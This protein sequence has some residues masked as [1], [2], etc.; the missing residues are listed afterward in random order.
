MGLILPGNYGLTYNTYPFYVLLFKIHLGLLNTCRCFLC[1]GY[2]H[3]TEFSS[4]TCILLVRSKINHMHVSG[5]VG[6][7]RPLN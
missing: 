4:L 7:C 5:L 3:T 1:L 6:W 2:W